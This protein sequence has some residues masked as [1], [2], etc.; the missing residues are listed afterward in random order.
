MVYGWGAIR[1]RRHFAKCDNAI[2]AE[3]YGEWS[4]SFFC[5]ILCSFAAVTLCKTW[6]QSWVAFWCFF[7]DADSSSDNTGSKCWID[8]WLIG[9]H[10]KGNSRFPMKVLRRVIAQVVSRRLPKAATRVRS[11]VRSCGICGGQSGSGAS[12]LRVLRFLLPILIPPTAQHSSTIIRSWY[13]RPVSGR[14]T[15]WAQSQPTPRKRN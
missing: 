7:Y 14:R 13:N 12:F 2:R 6:L 3:M 1:G 15:K 10:L 5:R 4:L 11:Q 9:R 8:K